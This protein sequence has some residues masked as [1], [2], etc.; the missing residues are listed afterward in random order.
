M[1]P[2]TGSG[3][4]SIGLMKSQDKSNP[5][6]PTNKDTYPFLFLLMAIMTMMMTIPSKITA[7]V[8]PAITGV[9]FAAESNNIT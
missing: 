6:N 1:Q 5:K 9:R 8:N 3:Y 2:F 7:E 4:V